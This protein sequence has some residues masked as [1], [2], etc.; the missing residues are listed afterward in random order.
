MT[1]DE[2]WRVSYTVECV[3]EAT[4]LC[5]RTIYKEM[6]SGRLKSFKVG[7][8]RLISASALREWVAERENEAK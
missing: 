1:I 3:A 8:R 2:H 7:T 5:R 4:G 6:D